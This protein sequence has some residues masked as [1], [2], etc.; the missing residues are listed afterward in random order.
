MPSLASFPFFLALNRREL[1]TDIICLQEFFV[2]D[3]GYTTLF[4]SSLADAYD[5]YLHPRPS[6]KDGLGVL[7][8]KG[9]FRLHGARGA[10]LS[11]WGSRVGLLMDL[12]TLAGATSEQEGQR[13]ILLST[14]LSFPHNRFDENQQH[15]QVSSL[16]RMLEAYVKGCPALG[17]QRDVLQIL[18]GDFNVDLT[19]PVLAPIHA[20]GFQHVREEGERGDGADFVTHRTHRGDDVAVDHIFYRSFNAARHRRRG[21]T[22]NTSEEDPRS[23]GPE[24]A[25]IAFPLHSSWPSF[26]A[27]RRSADKREGPLQ[28]GDPGGREKTEGSTH[29]IGGAGQRTWK[30]FIPTSSWSRARWNAR[31]RPMYGPASTKSPRR[32]SASSVVWGA[33]EAKAGA[34]VSEASVPSVAVMDVALCPISLDVGTWPREFGEKISDHRPLRAS[35]NVTRFLIDD[36]DTTA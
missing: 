20:L 8:R 6:K 5:F 28:G 27:R 17:G 14:H 4:S 33:E 23:R 19:N 32:S 12:E 22:G 18:C 7:L 35:L 13:I 24:G 21:A 34:G 31:S 15:R 30:D 3:E 36:Q 25:T 2:Q 26:W 11:R 9:K 10:T 29:V 1:D 16:T